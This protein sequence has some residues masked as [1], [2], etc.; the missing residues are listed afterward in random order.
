MKGGQTMAIKL[1]KESTFLRDSKLHELVFIIQTKILMTTVSSSQLLSDSLNKTCYQ[2]ISQVDS[3]KWEELVSSLALLDD[4]LESE[5][6]LSHFNSY[7][8]RG[9]KS[10]TEILHEQINIA[11]SE[12]Q[13]RIAWDK[14]Q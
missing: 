2:L 3:E 11:T 6:V 13:K 10:E 14:N 5:K 7:N 8:E 1:K 9:E 4:W 12:I